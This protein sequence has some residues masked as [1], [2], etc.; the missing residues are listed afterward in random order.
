[1]NSHVQSQGV[2]RCKSS[3]TV[4]PWTSVAIFRVDFVRCVEIGFVR[5]EAQVVVG[6]EVTAFERTGHIFP[7]VSFLTVVN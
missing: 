6:N 7:V 3:C 4:F 2:S 5:H 1:M